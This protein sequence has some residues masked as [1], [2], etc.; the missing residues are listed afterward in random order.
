MVNRELVFNHFNNYVISNNIKYDLVISARCEL[1]FEHKIDLQSIVNDV[2]NNFLCI[3]S[4]Y[5]WLGGIND[6]IAFGNMETIKIYTNLFKHIINILDT[7]II[8]HP[9]TLLRKYLEKTGVNIKRP[10]IQYRFLG[11]IFQL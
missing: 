4:G 9:E 1:L 3:P 2:Q 6:H 5:D 7:G 8:F 11:N 10:E